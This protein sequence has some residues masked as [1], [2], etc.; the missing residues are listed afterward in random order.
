MC[1]RPRKLTETQE[2]ELVAWW[3]ARGSTKAKA[4]E[5]GIGEATLMAILQRRGAMRLDG[6]APLMPARKS[7]Q[8]LIMDCERRSTNSAE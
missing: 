6:S 4:R 1:G 5:L 7:K 8:R 2:Q 3:N